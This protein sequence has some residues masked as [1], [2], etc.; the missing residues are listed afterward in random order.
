MNERWLRQLRDRFTRD[1][2]EYDHPGHSWSPVVSKEDLA[3][4]IDALLDDGP[5]QPTRQK[6]AKL[7]GIHEKRQ[8][9]GALRRP[10][11][12]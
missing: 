6:A 12:T 5:D 1:L 3:E 9:E 10:D 4:L 11:L 8:R 2:W 7:A